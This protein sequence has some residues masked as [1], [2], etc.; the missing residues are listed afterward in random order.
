MSTKYFIMSRNNDKPVY[1]NDSNQIIHLNSSNLLCYVLPQ[2]L[3]TCYCNNGLFESSLIDWCKQLCGK[4]KIFLDIG[5]HTGTYA[6]S[7]SSLCKKVY[8]FE[9]QRMTYYALCGS[10]AL[11]NLDNVVCLNFGLGSEEQSG[12]N[13]LKIVSDDGGGSSLH[14]VGL[15]VLREEEIEIRTLDSL[16]LNDIGFIKMD[17]EDNE[18]FVLLGAEKT[19]KRCGYPKILFECNKKNEQLFSYFGSFNYRIVSVGGVSN[20]YLAEQ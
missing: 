7:L 4:D 11:S 16:E 1:N 8:C 20:M 9:P 19:L 2:N 17:V 15:K 18:L 12:K 5:A 3:M 6:V 10:V 13:T 14:D